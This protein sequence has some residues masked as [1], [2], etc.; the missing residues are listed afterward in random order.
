MYRKLSLAAICAGVL[1]VPAAMGAQAHPE[2]HYGGTPS[3]DL[4]GGYSYVF[5]TFN[6]NSTTTAVTGRSGWD[7]SLKVPLFPFLGIKGD[8]SGSYL[9]HYG[10]PNLNPR[11]LI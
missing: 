5:R 8:V 10:D 11:S 7:A 6:P 4:Y 2:Y 9:N 3:F 1:A